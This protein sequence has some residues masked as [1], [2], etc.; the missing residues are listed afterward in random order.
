MLDCDKYDYPGGVN[1]KRLAIPI[2][3]LAI[4]A[5]GC[6]SVRPDT[7]L[8]PLVYIDSVSSA[9]INVEITLSFPD[10]QYLQRERL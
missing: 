2:L 1:L 9:D 6:A 5:A 10:M 4:I 3:L 7:K 8:P